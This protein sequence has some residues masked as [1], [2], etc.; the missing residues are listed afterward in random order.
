M[1]QYMTM[2]MKK[3]STHEAEIITEIN[4]ANLGNNPEGE[5]EHHDDQLG[6]DSTETH[7]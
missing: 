6:H 1:K 4:A 2:Y 5:D 7:R 3:S